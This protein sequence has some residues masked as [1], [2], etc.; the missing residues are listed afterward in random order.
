MG[1]V[2]IQLGISADGYLV[3]RRPIQR[4]DWQESRIA[5]APLAQEIAA[6]NMEVGDGLVF[7]HDGPSFARAL[8]VAGLQ[9][10]EAVDFPD[11]SAA[12]V[13]RPA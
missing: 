11:G 4:A 9:L 12:R 5:R 1:R 10:V 2:V 6:L 8:S 3:N 7:A 13:Y